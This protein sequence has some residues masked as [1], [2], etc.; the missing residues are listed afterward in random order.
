MS[1]SIKKVQLKIHKIY[2]KD[3]SFEAPNAFVNVEKWKPHVDVEI[4][5]NSRKLEDNRYEMI[6]RVL[7]TAKQEGEIAFLLEIQQAGV[8]TIDGLKENQTHAVLNVQC[9]DILFPFVRE[10]VSDLVTKGGFPQLLLGPMNFETLYRQKADALKERQT[11]T[12]T[13]H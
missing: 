8:F 1:E 4:N 12:L 9:P 13:T 2:L 6:L 11:T 7:I 10:A 3:A 5:A